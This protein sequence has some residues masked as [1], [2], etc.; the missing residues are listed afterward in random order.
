MIA[1]TQARATARWDDVRVF[2]ALYRGRT[3][4]A[5]GASVGLDAST[6]SRRLV[7]LEE[8]TDS[9]LFERTRDGLVPTESAE[10]LLPAAEEMAAAHARFVHDAAGFER[11]SE[12]T[13]RLSMPPGLAESFL[14]P[15]L[16]RLRARHPRLRIQLD[17]SVRFADLTRREA[18]LAIRTRRPT[19]GD[20]ISVK[21]GERRWTPMAAADSTRR[22][23]PLKNWGDIPWIGWA[24][25]VADFPPARW[26][27]KHVPPS[28][29]VLSTSHFS[30]QLAAVRSGLGAAL[31]PPVYTRLAAVTRL[32]HSAALAASIAELPSSDTW[33]VGHRALRSVPR[34]AAVWEFLVQEFSAFET[35]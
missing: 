14:G 26:L 4:A 9:R 35:P 30:T 13:V 22:R 25:D 5:A 17:A 20:L 10:L 27:A 19:S 29:I 16:V 3:L 34:I 28:A 32:Q 1:S 15:A 33:L 11:L 31:L 8:L 23:K 6:L 21:L 7:L 24:E 2:L 12:G 18:D